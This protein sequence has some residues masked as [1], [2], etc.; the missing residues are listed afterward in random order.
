MYVQAM[1]RECDFSDRKYEVPV[2]GAMA[3]ARGASGRYCPVMFVGPEILAEH[4]VTPLTEEEAY[5]KIKLNG[6]GYADF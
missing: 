2:M 3:V 5:A 6:D 4:G 1:V